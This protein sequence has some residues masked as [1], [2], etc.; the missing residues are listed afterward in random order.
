MKKIR[1]SQPAIPV[2][3]RVKHQ[4]F[5][6]SILKEEATFVIDLIAAI[7]VM[8]NLPSTYQQFVRLFVSTLRKGFKRLDIVIDTYRTN[9]IKG[10][11]IITHGSS[12]RV[13]IESSKSS[14]PHDSFKFLKNGENKTRVIEIESEV[15]RNNFSKVLAK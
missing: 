2:L 1:S 12:Q 5:P 8:I 13:I 11:E 9:L 6:V 3:N 7:S 14:L 10:G 4:T 15:L